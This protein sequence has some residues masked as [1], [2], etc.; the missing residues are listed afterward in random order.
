[1]KDFKEIILLNSGE[2]NER[3]VW[4][5]LE[6]N[7]I[8]RFMQLVRSNMPLTTDMLTAMVFFDYSDDRIKKVL[9]QFTKYTPP[10]VQWIRNYFPVDELAEVLPHFQDNLP[11]D[12]PSNKDCV[13]FKLWETLCNRK[14]F[15]AVAQNAPEFL[16]ADRWLLYS[17]PARV[18]LIKTDFAKYAPLFMQKG[19]YGSIVAVEGGWKYLVDHGQLQWLMSNDFFGDLLPK[20]EVIDYALQQGLVEDLYKAKLYPELLARRQFEVFVKN[21]SFNKDF[22]TGYPEEVDWEDLWEHCEGNK[23]SQNY[24]IEKARKNKTVPKCYDFLIAHTKIWKLPWLFS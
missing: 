11:E 5:C 16:E 1:M 15:D 10:V 12:W 19:A 8:G 18:A 13:R 23:E 9:T 4:Y 14:Q 17:Y 2:Q 6:H 24:L 3:M 7:E 20:D 21:H 22:L